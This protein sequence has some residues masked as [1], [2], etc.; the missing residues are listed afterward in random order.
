M[1]KTYISEK[2]KEKIESTLRS[3]GNELAAIKL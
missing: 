1:G 3:L 2:Q